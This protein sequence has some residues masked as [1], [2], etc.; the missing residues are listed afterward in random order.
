MKK[1]L[2]SVANRFHALK[3]AWSQIPETAFARDQVWYAGLPV[4]P[5]F[6]PDA[7][8]EGF[9]RQLSRLQDSLRGGESAAKSS[10]RVVSPTVL[11]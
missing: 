9:S 3:L 5:Y 1:T 10:I 6:K 7:E 4:S 2:Q 8:P 11:T